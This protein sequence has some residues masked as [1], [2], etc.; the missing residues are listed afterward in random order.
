M[1]P[2]RGPLEGVVVVV[3]LTAF[4]IFLFGFNDASNGSVVG[5]A[6]TRERMSFLNSESQLGGDGASV[7]A[8]EVGVLVLCRF[9]GVEAWA[10]TV[11]SPPGLRMT[12]RVERSF[13]VHPGASSSEEEESV[14]SEDESEELELSLLPFFFFFFFFDLFFFFFFDLLLR[15]VLIVFLML[16]C[17]F[18]LARLSSLAL[19]AW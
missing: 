2:P 4:G 12:F 5:G 6:P 9:P 11:P 10:E 17:S 1:F 19:S 3:V 18:F 8:G 15:Q 16:L 13:F 14:S 7:G